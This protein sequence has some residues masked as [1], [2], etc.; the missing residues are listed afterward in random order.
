MTGPHASDSLTINTHY[1]LSKTLSVNK[2]HLIFLLIQSLLFSSDPHIGLIS[3][4]V[5][6]ISNNSSDSSSAYY[7]SKAALNSVGESLAMDLEEKGVIVVL[8]HL[9]YVNTGLD[10]NGKTHLMSEAVEPKEAARKLWRMLMSNGIEDT[11]MFWHSEGMNL[12]W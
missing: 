1:T 7:Y 10:S 12:A 4:G 5:G 8:M 9:G 2:F 3:S 11:G 6:S